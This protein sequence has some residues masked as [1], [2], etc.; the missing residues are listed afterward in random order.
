MSEVAWFHE[1]GARNVMR[2]LSRRGRLPVKIHL[3]AP[4]DRSGD[5]KHLAHAAREAIAE[6]L[7]FKLHPHS[8]IGERK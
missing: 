5:R 7:G 6:T 2:L 4:L 3:L 8:P 1:P